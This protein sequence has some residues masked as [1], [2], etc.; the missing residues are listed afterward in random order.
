MTKISNTVAYSIVNSISL[1][2]YVIGSRGE[3]SNL[4]T[5]NFSMQGISNLVLG[6]LT[7]IEG[8]V[9]KI[10]QLA[11]VTSE[12]SPSVVANALSPNYAVAP[13]ENL[14]LDLNGHQYLLKTPN[15]TIGV[16]GV[17]LTDDDFIDFPVNQGADGLNANMTR[18]SV[19]SNEIANSGSKTFA[20]TESQN[21][22]WAV[23]TRLRFYNS[24]GNYME[25][26]VTSVSGTS[27]TATMDNSAGN[28]TYT[29]WVIGIAGDKGATG[30]SGSNGSNGTNGLN[31]DMTRTST[32]SIAIA[33]SG[34]KTL[35]YTASTNLG[36]LVGTRLRFANSISNYMEGA[37]TAVS[38]TSV[39]IDVDNSS[40]TGTLNSWNI[41]IAGDKGTDASNENLQKTI[42]YPGDF[43]GSNYTLVTGDN[44][45]TIIVDNGATDVTITVNGSLP[46]K[47]VAGF[48]QKGT[49]DV[50]FVEDGTTVNTPVGLLIKGENYAV[51]LEQEEASGTFYLLGNTKV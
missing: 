49:G 35:N 21:L 7:P 47:F 43:T 32:T 20:Y 8:G 22:G 16:G 48:I 14:Y 50:T 6:Q 1:Q 34:S 42:T 33:A 41:T 4:P 44:G 15:V 36:W 24:V 2:D 37:V 45:Y 5:N 31:A 9:L 39:T 3:P 40:G 17:T 26:V 13:Y 29:S 51:A 11:P 46:S 12:T 19:T 23:G 27:V 30:A 18:L 38:S 28:G 25:G 10:T